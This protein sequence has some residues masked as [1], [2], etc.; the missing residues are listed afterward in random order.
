MKRSVNFDDQLTFI[1]VEVGDIVE[2]RMLSSELKPVETSSTQVLPKKVLSI[3]CSF[4][5]RSCK[6]KEFSFCPFVQIT[7][8]HD[9]KLWTARGQPRLT[10]ISWVT[11]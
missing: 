8:F 9:P 4:S 7:K 10:R 11:L 2:N 1:A 5:V 3:S 6:P